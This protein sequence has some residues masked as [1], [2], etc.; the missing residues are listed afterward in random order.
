MTVQ[1]P[2][3]PVGLQEQYRYELGRVVL[4]TLFA[5]SIAAGLGLSLA[6]ELPPQSRELRRIGIVLTAIP[7]VL[8]EITK[9]SPRFAVFLTALCYALVGAI[10]ASTLSA[11]VGLVLLCI[12]TALIALLERPVWGIVSGLLA[13]CAVCLLPPHWVGT[14][15]GD[16][17]LLL[18]LIWLLQAIVCAAGYRSWESV[19]WSW[20]EYRHAEQL[21][22]DARDQRLALK[23]SEEALYHANQELERLSERLSLMTRIAEGAR[24]A[25]ER[26]LAEVSHEL[27]T[28]LNMILGYCEVI[29]DADTAYS[30]EIPLALRADLATVERNS[31][32][33]AGLVDDIL[34]L[35]RAEAGRMAL[36]RER[37]EFAEI[38]EGAVSAVGPLMRSRGLRLSVDLAKHLPPVLCDRLRIRQVLLNLLINAARFTEEGGVAVRAVQE[39]H[40]LVCEVEDTGAGIAVEDQVRIFEP[41]RQASSNS[42]SRASGTGL[43]LSLSKQLIEMHGGRMYVSSTIGIG[44]TFGFRLPLTVAGPTVHEGEFER[45]FS[46]YASYDEQSHPAGIPVHS[47]SAKLVVVDHNG[48]LGRVLSHHG[49]DAEIAF[50]PSLSEAIKELDRSPATALIVND[51]LAMSVLEGVPDL[52]NLPYRTPALVCWVPGREDAEEALGVG[53]YLTKP[54]S[55]VELWASVN[56][57]APNA[58]TVLILDDDM[59]SLQLLGRILETG[60]QGYRILRASSAERALALLT[61]HKPD[62]LIMDLVMDGLDGYALLAQ[63]K[64]DP[65][66]ADIPVIVASGVVPE[67]E[68]SPQNSFTVVQPGGYQI[69]EML[70][71][72]NALRLARRSHLE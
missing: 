44:S 51:D 45:W 12:P 31:R 72:I 11:S 35:S 25:K 22:E 65:M 16:K 36:R 21:L 32:C 15:L 46:P 1:S 39:G 67:Q 68:F 40:E 61:T 3:S 30:C 58:S 70:S 52:A 37:M 28:P 50:K 48:A 62:L 17:A 2:S 38:V 8:W 13:S 10:A 33:L 66:I 43:G 18:V 4:L 55:R 24:Q 27:R 59:A 19:S 69:D 56:R 41:F 20:S 71:Y 63:K 26:F 7:I 60:G 54:V 47:K 34:D 14:G 9:R 53:S 5:V 23:Q 49:V 64:Q 42:S 6:G 57:L 29:S